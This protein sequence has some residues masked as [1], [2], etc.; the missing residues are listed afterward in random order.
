[1]PDWPFPWECGKLQWRTQLAG[2]GLLE[3]KA[4][5]E[6]YLDKAYNQKQAG[7]ASSDSEAGSPSA[8]NADTTDWQQ[9]IECVEKDLRIIE[10]WM[11]FCK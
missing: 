7:N 8:V 4:E 10:K 9:R 1:M 5:L 3:V 2:R 6:E 11:N